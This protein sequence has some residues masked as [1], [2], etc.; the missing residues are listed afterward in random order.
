MYSETLRQ[1]VIAAIKVAGTLAGNRV[2]SPEDWPLTAA[3]IPAIMVSA[4]R[5]SKT[6]RG[7]FGPP[8]FD[9]ISTI[10]VDYTVMGNGQA[11]A[12]AASQ[13]IAAQIQLAVLANSDLIASVTQFPAVDSTA[14]TVTA[15]G[16][17]HFG[18]GQVSFQMSYIEDFI[19]DDASVPLTEMDVHIDLERPFDA[20]GTYAGS[21]FPDSV[22]SAPRS[23]GPD[24]RDEAA[25]QINLEG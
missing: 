24:G 11:L 17:E 9:T 6:S 3:K 14:P 8:S 5:D 15:E 10:L 22:T 2:Y 21:L 4:G 12:L 19:P 25:L 16:R 7:P 18:S 20:S 1:K 13:T 23:S